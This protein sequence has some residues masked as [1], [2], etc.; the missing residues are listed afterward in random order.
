MYRKMRKE[1]HTITYLETRFIPAKFAED[2]YKEK[3]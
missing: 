3:P 1:L 2:I